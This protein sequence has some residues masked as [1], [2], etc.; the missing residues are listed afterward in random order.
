[1]NEQTTIQDVLSG[2][3]PVKFQIQIET[4]SLIILGIVLIVVIGVGVAL[5]RMFKTQS[6]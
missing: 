2:N 4:K 5:H 1:M 3:A 6:A